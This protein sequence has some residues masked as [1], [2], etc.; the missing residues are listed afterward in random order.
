MK[1]ILKR[2]IKILLIFIGVLLLLMLI[3][4]TLFKD[5]ILNKVKTEINS[6][7]DAT[8]EFQDV[9]L[10]LFRSFPDFNLGLHELS[11]VGKDQFSNDTLVAFDA[12]RVEV[13][14]LSAI[15][16]KVEVEG[17]VLERPRMHARV[18]ADSSANWDIAPPADTSVTPEQEQVDTTDSGSDMRVALKHF[19]I[20]NAS[21]LYEDETASMIAQLEDWNLSLTGDFGANYS[22]MELSTAIKSI[23][24][25]MAGVQYLKNTSFSFDTKLGA[26]LE[27]MIFELKENQLMMNDLGLAF[28]GDVAM[29]AE[30]IDMNLTFATTNTS[31]KTLLSMVPAVFMQGYEDLQTFGN[32][33]LEGEVNGTYN[34]AE[35]LLPSAKVKL[36]VQDGRIS[37]PDLPK[38]IEQIAI[39]LQVDMNGVDLDKTTVN[40]SKF[41][42]ALGTNPFDIFAHVSTPISDPGIR[43]GMKGTLVLQ[44]L[45]DAL[46]L[47]EMKMAGTMKA[48]V[49]LDGHLSTLE[50]ENYEDFDATGSLVLNDFV[51]EMADLPDALHI[52][53][54]ELRFSPQ[55]LAV[56]S[57]DGK[58]GESDF[59]LNGRVENYLAYGLSDGTLRADFSMGSKYF[60]T[61]PFLE[62]EGEVSEQDVVTESSD[63]AQSSDDSVSTGVFLVPGDLDVK[64]TCEIDKLLYDKLEVTDLTGTVLV[65]EQKVHLDQLKMNLLEGS[66][67]VDGVYDTHDSERPTATMGLDVN[68][69]HVQSA[70]Q[71][72]SMLDTLA[73]VLRQCDG[74]ISLKLDYSSLLDAEMSPVL[75][76]VNGYGRLQS[77]NLQLV[78]NST[79]DK[80]TNLLKLGD[81]F[82]NEF[83]DVNI[84]FTIQNGRIVVEPFDAEVGDVKMVIGGSHG[85]DQTMDYD[86]N[87]QIPRQYVG[88]A[89]NDALEG[90]LAKAADKGVDVDLGDYI[91][92]KARIYGDMQDPKIGL[93]Y[94]EASGEAKQQLKE[95]VKEELNKQK[96]IAEQKAREEASKKAQELIKNAEAEAARIKKEAREAADKLLKEADEKAQKLV[97]E[98]AKEGM[99][100]KIAAEKAADATKKEARKQADNLIKKADE[101]ADRI[102]EDARQKAAE[103][104]QK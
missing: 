27:E 19:E 77:N 81:K 7:V 62:S 47:E 16:G 94:G 24:V 68:N 96:E 10:S 33:L 78:N 101:K 79:Y 28:S 52:S 71:S 66:I 49:Q 21:V 75:S 87:M 4:P 41:H 93:N 65:K 5:Q 103:I 98:A 67:G 29:P 48:D 51:L 90:L 97:D 20:R 50:Q 74:N 45:A 26:N 44:S 6:Q 59:F 32:L 8:V 39:D 58:M 61:N 23:N 100:A 92:V 60:N 13:D 14:L 88:T 54:A 25:K 30:D 31:F 56:K 89:A 64:L 82:D 91:P 83:K 37:Y 12:F 55:F 42:F 76:S 95:K 3:I 43:A 80:L 15:R 2:F 84:S 86:L 1:K 104:E 46:P 57:F 17:I 11:V 63:E 69:M 85:L 53:E 38:S 22:D 99:L 35:E 70:V 72:F 102:V 9:S 36:S 40:L 73:P 18:L 34:A